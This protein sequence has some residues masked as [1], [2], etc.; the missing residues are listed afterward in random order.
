MSV[1]DKKLARAYNR[2]LAHEKAGKFALA[3]K[4]YRECL[5]LDPAD[6]GGVAIRL[7]SMGEGPQP[8][9]APPAY[10]AT[11]FDQHA[12]VFDDI[13][14]RDLGYRIPLLVPERLSALKRERFARMLDL[15]CGTGLTGEAMR[16]RVD[17][18]VGVDLSEAI[19]AMADERGC[20]DDLYLGEAAAFIEGWD[21][22][23]FDLITATDMLPYFGAL[24][25]VFTAIAKALNPDGIFV[26][27]TETLEDAAFGNRG[28]KVGPHQRFHHKLN[29][30]EDCLKNA[31]LAVLHCETCIVRTD[32]GVPQL[33]HLVV[34]ARVS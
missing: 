16:D 6:F 28:W 13:L 29:Y 21:E 19:L 9:C 26:F 23:P 1:D 5:A 4:A 20:Y 10:V 3:A 18:I 14:V 24:Q 8:D 12:G 15:G 17:M 31:K 32:E 11:L 34:A 7:A 2:G 25:P 22:G 33:G 30:V 27:S